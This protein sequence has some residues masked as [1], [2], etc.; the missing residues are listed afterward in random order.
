METMHAFVADESTRRRY[1]ARSMIGWRPFGHALPNNAHHALARLE[2]EVSAR[3][4]SPGTSTDS[5]GPPGAGTATPTLDR[6][7]FSGFAVPF[8]C[9]L[10]QR[11]QPDE[12]SSVKE[13]S[14]VIRSPWPKTTSRAPT[15]CVVG[16]SGC[17]IARA[18]A[19]RGI[20]IA[21]VNLGRRRADYPLALE[22]EDRCEAASCC[23]PSRPSL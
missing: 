1:W 3:S 20:P 8:C 18:A 4:F 5:T 6:L 23:R 15:R 2:A 17:R 9:C 13:R 7:D 22:E 16:S 21:A 14:R 19:R 11:L 12:Y 10:R